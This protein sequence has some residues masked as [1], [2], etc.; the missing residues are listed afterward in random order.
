MPQPNPKAF[1]TWAHRESG[2]NDS[3][4]NAWAKEV[5]TFAVL[6]RG[7]GIDV[8]LDLFHQSEPGIDWTR[9]GPLRIRDVEWVIVVL[10]RAWRECWEGRNAASVGAG[11]V[12]EADVLRSIFG[13]SQQEFHRKVVLATLPSFRDDDVVPDGLDGVHRFSIR[14]LTSEK[15]LPV[16][17]L[18]VG[19]PEY[20]AG[21]LGQLPELPPVKPLAPALPR[22]NASADLSAALDTTLLPG[23]IYPYMY[24]PAI[25]TTEKAFCV[26]S[27]AALR[28]PQDHDLDLGSAEEQ[29]LVVT[30][31]ASK[32]DAWIADATSRQRRP[33]NDSR[34]LAVS[35]TNSTVVTLQLPPVELLFHPERTI[36]GR[37]G[38]NLRP[39]GS[40]G[41]TGMVWVNVD[42]I[43]RPTQVPIPNRWPLSLEDLFSV[44]LAELSS[45]LDDGLVGAGLPGDS[46]SGLLA[47]AT[48]VATAGAP[49]GE[50]VPLLRP[51]W[52]QAEGATEPLGG[53]WTFRDYVDVTDP[54]QR[55]RTVRG[56][57]KR[58]VRD[59][60]VSGHEADVDNF[61]AH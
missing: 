36:E 42:V 29:L 23:R 31:S 39:Y 58:L 26:R 2:W 53:E 49:F 47:V 17:R 5:Y 45:L 44:V 59:A 1:V 14:E 7:H 28:L 48:V 19:K 61:G 41:A 21:P 8:D 22:A 51:S 50:F 46:P 54:V 37:L 4:A 27:A 43:V 13:D 20:P 18:L 16:V 11:A 52:R 32:L 55:E 15:V 40:A 12:A 60:G 6:L 38:Y 34:W 25:D 10:S 57:I 33:H 30:A 35:P 56:W 9:F 3:Q 24:M